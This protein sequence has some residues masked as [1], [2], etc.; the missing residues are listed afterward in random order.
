ME[1]GIWKVIKM[2]TREEHQFETKQLQ[3][4]L[5]RQIDGIIA[6][7]EESKR[8]ILDGHDPSWKIPKNSF[9]DFTQRCGELSVMLRLKN[10]F[11]KEK[12]SE[13]MTLYVNQKGYVPGEIKVNSE[14]EAEQVV[15]TLIDAQNI[16]GINVFDIAVLKNKEGKTIKEW[17]FSNY[18]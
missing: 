2:R 13:P 15:S 16:P 10:S 6:D 12:M 9:A 1:I 18:I 3:E 5:G 8:R 17:E 11:P 14:E 4:S 7:L